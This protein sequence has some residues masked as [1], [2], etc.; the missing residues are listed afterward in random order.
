MSTLSQF[1]G[2]GATK[3]IVNSCSTSGYTP[4]NFDISANGL[5]NQG[6]E[7]LSGALTANTLKTLLTVT[8]AGQMPF[9]TAYSKD[10]TT[11]TIRVVVIADG[12]TVFDSTSG[13][14]GSTNRGCIVAGNHTWVT[15]SGL[16][17]G[18]PIRWAQSLVVQVAS[19]LTE[20]DKVAIGYVL[21]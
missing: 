3:A 10:A 5:Q 4:T 12:V 20:T 11:R 2:G 15:A 18:S 13:S 17:Q 6:R 7:V 21:N 9:L 1:T 16:G 19:S 14:I 8:Q